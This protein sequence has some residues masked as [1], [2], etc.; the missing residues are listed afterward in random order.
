M[1]TVVLL[2]ACAAGSLTAQD[3]ASDSEVRHRL[4]LV[5]TRAIAYFQ[6]ADSIE[7]GLRTRGLM[8]RADLT[9]LRAQLEGALDETDSAIAR[10]DPRAANAALDR[11]QVL[12][13]RFAAKLG[14]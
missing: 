12:L 2:L 3:T 5:A 7:A 6:S 4:G 10:G 8:L 11:A 13:E 9:V 1:R 14:G